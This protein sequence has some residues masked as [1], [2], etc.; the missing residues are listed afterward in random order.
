MKLDVSDGLDYEPYIEDLDAIDK[1]LLVG[2][3]F[4]YLQDNPQPS[5]FRFADLGVVVEN[6]DGSDM[7]ATIRDILNLQP[8]LNTYSKGEDDK[9]IAKPNALTNIWDV[10]TQ[11]HGWEP[12]IGTFL[13][14]DSAKRE[15]WIQFYAEEEPALKLVYTQEG[16]EIF[17]K[18]HEVGMGHHAV[19]DVQD[20]Y[21]QTSEEYTSQLEKEK[22][23]E[24]EIKSTLKRGLDGRDPAEV[25]EIHRKARALLKS[26]ERDQARLLRQEEIEDR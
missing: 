3:I 5:W 24:R 17:W 16:S 14:Y 19:S 8:E 1:V 23:L 10:I 26:I 12:V 18:Q 15:L 6:R 21:S 22:R 9:W 4:V 2:L 11:P 20:L 7:T 13:T 25:E